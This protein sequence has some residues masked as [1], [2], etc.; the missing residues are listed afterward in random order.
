[1]KPAVNPNAVPQW[2]PPDSDVGPLAAAGHAFDRVRR[3]LRGKRDPWAQSTLRLIE[4]TEVSVEIADAPDVQQ[5]VRIVGD[6]LRRC[7]DLSWVFVG[8]HD[9]QKDVLAGALFGG[10]E[11]AALAV[12]VELGDSASALI[13]SLKEGQA[14]N[15]EG[16]R[17]LLGAAP[18]G[19]PELGPFVTYPLQKGLG[20]V[21]ADPGE[22]EPPCQDEALSLDLFLAQLGIAIEN[23]VLYRR[24]RREQH[25]RA[26]VT[27]S[28]ESGLVTID[29]Q[30]RVTGINTRAAEFLGLAAEAALGRPIKE[31]WRPRDQNPNPL[32]LTLAKGKAQSLKNLRIERPD[33]SQAMLQVKTSLLRGAHGPESGVVA[34][35]A[36]TS[37]LRRTDEEI[38]QLEKL[39]AIGR[40]TTSVAHEIRNPLAG[41]MTGVQYLAKRIPEE[42]PQRETIHFIINEIMRLDRII[43]DLYSASRPMSLF[44]EQVDAA[45]VVERALRSLVDLSERHEV[46][47]VVRPGETIP[48]IW[49]DADKIQQVLINLVKNAIEVSERGAEIEIELRAV[50]RFASSADL[51][52][53]E[54]SHVVISVADRGPG[55]RDEDQARIFEPFF[56]K[57]E[58]GTGL[59]LY[60]SHAIVE[61]H[62]GDLNLESR[63]GGGALATL[64]LPVGALEAEESR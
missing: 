18:R 52:S 41:I 26:S 31:L 22:R 40:L 64:E 47:V 56:S 46:A 6:F 21:A 39:A 17:A 45:E 5:A 2:P 55:L 16:T 20:I 4:L 57:K 38:F 37:R 32:L 58:E 60:V 24:L 15:G 61:R 25:F 42:D 63:T 36:D 3:L 9:R 44:R 43:V 54:T 34:E 10:E 49:V 19:A 48:P 62:G 50:N 14:V 23:A 29:R 1:M 35:L 8:L 13:R 28:I 11:G 33:G 12:E 7:L 53:G 30:T 59:G 27:N 51:S